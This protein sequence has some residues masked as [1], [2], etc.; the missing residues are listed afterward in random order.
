MLVV[1]WAHRPRAPLAG[2]LVGS[3]AGLLAWL[4]GWLACSVLVVLVVFRARRSQAPLV[5]LLVGWFA[6]CL[7]CSFLTTC[8]QVVGSSWGHLGPRSAKTIVVDGDVVLVV[9]TIRLRPQL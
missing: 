4:V 9:A 5:C 1:F 6:G 7:A 2:L 3:P 8:I